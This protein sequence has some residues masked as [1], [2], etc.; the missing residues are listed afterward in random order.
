[1]E[2][3]VSVQVRVNG[4]LISRVRL[5][6][7]QS[8]PELVIVDPA[9]GPFAVDDRDERFHIEV[10]EL[11]APLAARTENDGWRHVSSRALIA[12]LSPEAA[13]IDHIRPG[14][15]CSWVHA[16]DISAYSGWEART[17]PTGP[18]DRV[19]FNKA[20]RALYN[21]GIPYLLVGFYQAQEDGGGPTNAAVLIV[22]D[23]PRA[24][25]CLCS[26]GFEAHPTSVN[27][28][29]S[30]Q[31]NSAVHFVPDGKPKRRRK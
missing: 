28:V 21:T 15:R 16:S 7:P 11:D 22:P 27:V 10:R 6:G 12:I 17:I 31:Y 24:H 20:V 30:N 2:P 23:A 1:M 19:A 14:D 26:N 5:R 25:D 29:I 8:D 9:I 3:Q 4:I 18:D 13:D